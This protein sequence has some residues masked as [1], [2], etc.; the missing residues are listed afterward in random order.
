MDWEDIEGG[1]I[2]V[3][4]LSG[5]NWTR[6]GS[7]IR[8]N[9]QSATSTP[10]LAL[11]LLD[12][13]VVA[14]FHIGESEKL[15]AQRWNE[16]DWEPLG[17]TVNPS[18]TPST[19]NKRVITFNQNNQP[20]ITWSGRATTTSTANDFF[21][22]QWTDNQWTSLGTP[23]KLSAENDRGVNGAYCSPDEVLIVASV[24]NNAGIST[25]RLS[26]RTNETWEEIW[27]SGDAF[28]ETNFR[29]YNSSMTSDARG[30]IVLAW[31]ERRNDHQDDILVYRKNK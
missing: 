9:T 30:S 1:A 20:I 10:T 5:S 26:R 19:F 17:N 25:L 24:E 8:T 4:Q 15:F 13:P 7:P 11:D 2:H 3:Y 22:S 14:F 6:V 29:F 28:R 31:T 12:H 18:D 23:P 21:S 16:A 27:S